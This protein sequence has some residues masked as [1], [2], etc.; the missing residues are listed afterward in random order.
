MDAKTGKIIL[1][2][3]IPL[4]ILIVVAS[5]IGIFTSDL[6]AKET[7]NWQV[8]CIGQ[9]IID[10]FLVVPALITTAV[11]AYRKNYVARL[12]WV[13][14]IVYTL[15]TFTIYSFSVHFNRLFVVYCFTLGLSFYSLAWFI[16]FQIKSP[17]MSG[18]NKSIV[19]KAT[20][21][22]FFILS[23][24]FYF[25]WVSEIVPAIVDN[26]VPNGLTE[27]GLITNPVQ[28]IDLSIFLPGIF[29]TGILVL[30]GKPVGV[31]FTIIILT[32]FV[33]MNITI[34]WLAFMMKQKG[35]E[36]NL[37]VTIMMVV[38]CLI[39]FAF[40]V[41]NIKNIKIKTI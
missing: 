32:F 11:L 5:C 26:T 30:K 22:F 2:L 25:L 38:L 12:L 18:I 31:L 15:Y 24:A 28:V 21:I 20:G 39:S 3:S 23:L 17:T 35:L 9:D 8:Q 27:T 7:V 40:L 6:Y 13:G 36:S 34:G 29:I 14:V 33:L 41:W 19:A 1:S 16:Y 37:S 10:L 4:S